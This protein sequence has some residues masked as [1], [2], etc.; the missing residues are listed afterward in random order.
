MAHEFDGNKYEKASSHQKEWGEKIIEEF[1]LTGTE[2]ILDLGCGDGTLTVQ[3][4][5]GFLNIVSF[6]SRCNIP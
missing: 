1:T 2:R 6:S 4:F 5:T 3:R